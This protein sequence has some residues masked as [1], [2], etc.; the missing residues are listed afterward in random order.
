MTNGILS[1]IFPIITSTEGGKIFAYFLMGISC[2][3]SHFYVYYYI[4]ETKGKS[5]DENAQVFS[6]RKY[7]AHDNDRERGDIQLKTALVS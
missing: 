4:P 7:I 5:I 3:I 6:G 1:F 2:I